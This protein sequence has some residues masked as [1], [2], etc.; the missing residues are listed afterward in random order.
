MSNPFDPFDNVADGAR[1]INRTVNRAVKNALEAAQPLRDVATDAVPR[2]EA[3]KPMIDEA[4]RILREQTELNRAM[5]SM[6]R[7][8]DA[9]ASLTRNIGYRW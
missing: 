8:M 1:S 2:V 9:A 7:E 4:T 3:A 6:R 5:R